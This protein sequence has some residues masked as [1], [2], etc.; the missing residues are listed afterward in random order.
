MRSR[1][2]T[3]KERRRKKNVRSART[4]TGKQERRRYN[5]TAAQA[6]PKVKNKAW[7]PKTAGNAA[8][9]KK[10]DTANDPGTMYIHGDRIDYVKRDPWPGC[11]VEYGQ[12]VRT[13]C[14]ERHLPLYCVVGGKLCVVLG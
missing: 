4:R 3:A 9:D 5:D 7:K 13:V 11:E 1:C 2:R 8:A 10:C 14:T 12:I 6:K